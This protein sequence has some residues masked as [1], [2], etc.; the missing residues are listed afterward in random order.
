MFGPIPLT[1]ATLGA[2][3]LLVWRQSR[4]PAA[5]AIRELRAVLEARGEGGL[6]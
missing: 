2:V 5:R 4:S 6:D 1:I 3:G